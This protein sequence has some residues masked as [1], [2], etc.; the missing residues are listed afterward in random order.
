MNLDELKLAELW[1]YIEGG[2]LFLDETS[3][4]EVPSLPLA[5]SELNYY[6]VSLSPLDTRTQSLISRLHIGRE[7]TPFHEV[8]ESLKRMLEAD[9]RTL[10]EDPAEFDESYGSIAMAAFYQ[11]VADYLQ[12]DSYV[13]AAMRKTIRNTVAD[14]LPRVQICF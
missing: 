10:K 4:N 14:E 13:P 11:K 1:E 2:F 8:P 7:S 12:A 3:E 5:R 6:L 9:I